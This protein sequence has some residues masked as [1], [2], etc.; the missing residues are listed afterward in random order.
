VEG[1]NK[2]WGG[3]RPNSGRPEASTT[4]IRREFRKQLAEEMKKDMMEWLLAI[5][6]AALGHYAEKETKFGKKKVYF[7]SPDPKAWDIAMSRAFGKPA[8]EEPEFGQ[9]DEVV[10]REYVIRRGDSQTNKE[11]YGTDEVRVS[12]NP[13]Q[14]Q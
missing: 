9:S 6:S 2:N 8:M 4:L 11:Q 12:A 3:A 7:K 14:G 5:R 1:K 10:L 13:I